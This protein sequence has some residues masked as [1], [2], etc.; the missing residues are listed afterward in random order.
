MAR[1][2]PRRGDRALVTPQHAEHR[3]HDEEDQQAADLHEPRDEQAVAPRRRVVVK[4]AQQD[5]VAERAGLA[6]R[7]LEQRELEIARR[8]VDA[9]EVAR[10]HAVGS[11]HEDDRGMRERA[12]AR[13][14][15]ELEAEPIGERA[16]ARARRRRGMATR[17]RVGLA[18]LAEHAR[19]L[20]RGLIDALGRVEADRRDAILRPELEALALEPG[21]RG[22]RAVEH[23]AAQLRTLVVRE[24]EQDRMRAVEQLAQARTRLTAAVGEHQI[25]RQPRRR[26]AR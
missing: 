1:Y 13:I 17:D 18:E 5:L 9:V 21:H 16:H 23:E 12:G 14:A 22:D 24:H 15:Q 7:R 26:G 3:E 4:A 19:L 11:Q 2:L 6:V 10:D 8:V 20:A 25:E